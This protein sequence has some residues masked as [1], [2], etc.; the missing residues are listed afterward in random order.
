VDTFEI[1]KIRINRNGSQLQEDIR[2]KTI[3]NIF[4]CLTYLLQHVSF[5]LEA[6]NNS[7]TNKT[8]LI[9]MMNSAIAANEILPKQDI[10][11]FLACKQVIRQLHLL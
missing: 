1:E 9:Y 10:K 7:N 3:I 11:L 6:L 4:H 8:D 5:I 2:D